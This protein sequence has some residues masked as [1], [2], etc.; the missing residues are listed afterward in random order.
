RASPNAEAD[1]RIV[2][3]MSP[4]TGRSNGAFDMRKFI[5]AAAVIVGLFAASSP[6]HA[7]Y[8]TDAFGCD[9]PLPID[10]PEILAELESTAGYLKEMATPENMKRGYQALL[11]QY[12]GRVLNLAIVK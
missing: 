3:I 9:L 11:A 1:P 10:D 7:K 4:I 12:H 2:P 8:P 6:T 5:A